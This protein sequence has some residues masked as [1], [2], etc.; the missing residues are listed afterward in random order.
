MYDVYEIRKD[1]PVLEKIIYLDSGATTQTPKPAVLAMNDFF[2][3]Y[4]ANY[5][6]GAHQ[7]SIQA[8][9]AFEDAREIIA[10]FLNA[11][12]EK[13]IMTKNTTDSI[14][15]VANGFDFQEGDEIITTVVEHHSNF[16]PWLRQKEKGVQVKVADID[17]EG[18]VNPD[19]IDEMITDKTKMIAIG[20]ISNVFGSIQNIEKIIQIARKN[21]IPI[22]IDGA[23]SAGHMALDLKALDCDYFAA[24]GHKGLLG[25]QG[26][27]IL[28]IKNPETIQPTVLG[29]GTTSDADA[30]SYAL[31]SSPECFEAGTPNLPGVI[32]LGAAV[33]YLQKIG[34][35]AVEAHDNH[36]A[37]ETAKRL[38]EI[39]S[40]HGNNNTN[41]RNTD[42]NRITV[43]GPD[44]RAGLVSFN[45][46]GLTPHTV[47]MRLDK[48]N[49][50]VRSGYHCAIPGQKALGIDGSVRAS[51]GLYNTEEE[52]DTFINAV[53]EIADSVQR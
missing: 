41:N 14:N 51:F 30:C 43:Y 52:V 1:F 10:D 32:G 50:C 21:N 13:M 23:Q 45:I 48:Y 7:L 39:N 46:E 35:E 6:R 20:H 5:G 25:P 22:L 42:D 9:N 27:G 34:V 19:Q 40:T 31:K 36:L 12:P 18:F 2:Y 3:N 33:E 26:T 47:A 29:G 17:V 38:K 8:T 11:P 4:A 24:A 53:S 37:R 49:I 15:I 44:N 16:V 28:Y